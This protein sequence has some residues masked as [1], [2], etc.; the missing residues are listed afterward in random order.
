MFFFHLYNL[1]QKNISF[2]E[3]DIASQI[4]DVSIV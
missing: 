4:T 2:G 3:S 1:Q